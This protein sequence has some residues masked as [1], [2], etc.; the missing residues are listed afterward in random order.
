MVS[1]FHL[2]SF[3]KLCFP[4]QASDRKLPP[5]QYES[6]PRER[7]LEDI[8]KGSNHRLRHRES[9]PDRTARKGKLCSLV[10]G[11]DKLLMKILYY[12]IWWW[13]FLKALLYSRVWKWKMYVKAHFSSSMSKFDFYVTKIWDWCLKNVGHPD[14]NGI[15][16]GLSEYCSGSS[17]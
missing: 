1:K 16:L 4:F 3:I 15:F 6:T 2:H 9:R 13:N 12:R 14:W 7:L 8:K 11:L 5:R 10:M 17:T